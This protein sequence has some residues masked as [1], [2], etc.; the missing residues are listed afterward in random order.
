MSALPQRPASPLAPPGTRLRALGIPHLAQVLIIENAAY[1][2]PWTRENFLSSLASGYLA[3]GLFDERSGQLIGYYWAMK[4]V[5]E[6]HLLNLTVAP[7]E[8][9]RGHAR[10]LLHVLHVRALQ[11]GCQ[12]LWLEVRLSNERARRL[13][14]LAG[15]REVARRRAYYPAHPHQ[16]GREDAIVM[17]LDLREDADGLV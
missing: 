4:G 12:Q 8:Q 2:F 3:E 17:S 13:Y 11:E 15:Y 10:T 7:S 9:R 16:G 1:D 6:M 14:A 5:D